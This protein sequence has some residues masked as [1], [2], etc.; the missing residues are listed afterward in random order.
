MKIKIV[1]ALFIISLLS[2]SYYKFFFLKNTIVGNWHWV[3]P[4]THYHSFL[5]DGTVICFN[6]PLGAWE[7]INKNQIYSIN[8]ENIWI[9]RLILINNFLIGINSS[10]K[11]VIAYRSK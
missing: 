11:I 8:W 1:L 4:V 9:D 5:E 2:F 6:K 3:R 7:K 10:N